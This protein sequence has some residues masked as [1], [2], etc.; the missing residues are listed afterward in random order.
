MSRGV[1][2]GGAPHRPEHTPADED[3]ILLEDLAP[4]RDVAGGRKI[5][6][7][8]SVPDEAPASRER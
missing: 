4:R 1:E 6:L 8:E 2:N 3:V 7:G 5:T